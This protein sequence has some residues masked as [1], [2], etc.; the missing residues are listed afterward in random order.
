MEMMTFLVL[1]KHAVVFALCFYVGMFTSKY[2]KRKRLGELYWCETICSYHPLMNKP[3]Y[4]RTF[5]CFNSH[6]IL[7]SKCRQDRL[8]KI[9]MYVERKI[10]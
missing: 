2:C 5:A 10:P 9:K 6:Q 7:D 4:E 3:G 8:D 1:L